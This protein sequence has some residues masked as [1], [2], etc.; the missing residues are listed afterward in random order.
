MMTETI[1]DLLALV[2]LTSFTVAILTW[3]ELVAHLG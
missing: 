2:A 3:S 1:K